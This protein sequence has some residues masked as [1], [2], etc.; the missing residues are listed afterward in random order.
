MT[1]QTS[2]RLPPMP[3]LDCPF[4]ESRTNFTERWNFGAMPV[5]ATKRKWPGQNMMALQCDNSH[6]QM[7]IGGIYNDRGFIDPYWPP[8]YG[9]K[10][11]PDVPEHIGAAANEAHVALSAGAPRAAIAIARA[12]VEATAKAHNVVKGNLM[13]KIDKLA[14]AGDI[15]EH[16]RT[17]AHE[18][19][20]A[21]NEVAHG[22]LAEEPI[23]ADEA[24]EVLDL[25][26]VYQEPAQVEHVRERRKA[27]SGS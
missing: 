2:H 27:R 3:D 7:I 9:G 23:T 6:C 26:A 24:R 4:C 14:E 5:G 19:R 16:M 15:S 22:D 12:V 8:S 18:I 25:M 10:A 1:E 21:G 20:F 13:Q 17:A 11:F